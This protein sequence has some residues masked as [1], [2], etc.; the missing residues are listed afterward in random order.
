[1]IPWQTFLLAFFFINLAIPFCVKC[2]FTLNGYLKNFFVVFQ[3]KQNQIIQLSESDF[4]GS[5]NQRIRLKGNS[6]I[7][8]WISFTGEYDI[9]PRI[10]DPVLFSNTLFM[11]KINPLEYRLIDINGKIYPNSENAGSSFGLFQNLD[12]LFLTIRLAFADI[13]IGRQ[14]IAWGS[15]RVVNPTDVIA[16]FTFSE[17]D[18]EERFGIDGIR[19]RMP[20]GLLGEFDAGYIPGK[21]GKWENNA[22]FTRLKLYKLESD[23]SMMLL[24]FRENLLIGFDLARAV[25]GAGFWL[26]LAYVL[27]KTLTKN[28]DRNRSKYFRS[29]IGLDYS[30]TSKT[31]GFIEYHYN[32]AG[33]NK[34]VNYLENLSK[35]AFREGNVYLLS[36]HYLIPGIS[37]Q[38]H[39]L[40]YL[41][42]QTLVNLLDRSFYLAIDLEYNIDQNIYLEGG[43]FIASGKSS[44]TFHVNSEFGLYPNTFYSSFRIY[45]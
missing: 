37:Y 17:L 29:S 39:P 36:T 41:N 32:S 18:K 25:G 2:E 26:E 16:P 8:K 11:G 33:E 5:V 22:F 27:D 4:L 19:Y 9:S 24:G 42:S 31:Y 10:Q 12:R 6:Q 35:I 34:T 7:N 13:Y 15:A 30:L 45:F 38:I 14:A 20:I 1:M 43:Y 23:I 21:K 3:T 40:V 44:D 28:T